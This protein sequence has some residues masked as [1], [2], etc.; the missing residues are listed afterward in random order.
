MVVAA[1]TIA[2]LHRHVVRHH[3][4]EGEGASRRCGVSIEF[5]TSSPIGTR[6]ERGEA[7]GQR[8][9]VRECYVGPVPRWESVCGNVRGELAVADTIIAPP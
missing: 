9:R 1:A 3:G 8:G 6:A 7:R 5:C 4:G 2:M